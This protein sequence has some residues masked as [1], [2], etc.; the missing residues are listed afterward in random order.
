MR[1][2]RT[3]SID[4]GGTFTDVLSVDESGVIQS[5]KLPTVAPS[6]FASTLNSSLG[7]IS[8]QDELLYST[9]VTLNSLLT[10]T[11]P[12]IG[13]V[14]TAGFR[15]ILETARLP[16]SGDKAS[17]NQLPRRLVSIEWVREIQ[18]RLEATGAVRIGIDRSEIEA[19]AQEYQAADISVVAVSLL[20]SYLD[21]AHEQAVAEVFAE[22]TPGI[23]VVLSST[24]L[25]ELREYERTLT[26]ALNSC[27]IPSLEEHLDSLVPNSNKSTSQIWL[28]QSNGGLSSAESLSHQPLAT[29][30]SGPGAAVVGMHWLGEKSGFE[31]FI[32]LDVGGTSTDVALITNGD[33]ALTTR[34]SVAGFPIKTP[35]LDVFSIGAGGGSI[36]HEGFDRRWH[37]GPE[38]AGARPG[39]ACYGHGGELPTLT[40]AQLVLGRIPDALLGGSV[41]LD[42]TRSWDV[43]EIFG[44]NRGFDVLTTARGILEIASH[45]MC[46]AIRR[47]SVSR[48]CS[49]TDHA[50]LAMGGAGP[51]HAAE[52]ADLLGMTTVIVP[53]QPGLAAAWGLLAA[54]VTRDFVL[55]CGVIDDALD[56]SKIKIG[57]RALRGRAQSWCE[58]EPFMGGDW[59]M[60]AKLDL[61]YVGMTQELT[62][63]CP[64]GSDLK[65]NVASTIDS[66]HDH[67][68]QLS[69]RTWRDREAVEIVNLRLTV[70]GLRRKVDLPRH[71]PNQIKNTPPKTTR[72]VGYLGTKVLQ[73]TPI[74]DRAALD[75]TFQTVGPAII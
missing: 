33:Y 28:M 71:V 75:S 53:P 49:P 17:S 10:G 54:D 19:I 9:T 51:L 43:L 25:P 37:V 14:V 15:D 30:L 63:E 65:K 5:F 72:E 55:P 23:K 8:K 68:E 67:F 56:V 41:P 73:P 52:L 42:R 22:V 74:Y 11:L 16:R 46:G 57:L 40:D 50:L 61:R 58:A 47:V 39:P 66:F 69:G 62:I 2:P 29:A 20:H 1:G 13:L 44:Q 34:G 3:I 59:L 26:T 6:E 36:A 70:R 60:N 31:N 35:M 27:L 18:A 21:P 24:V 64:S 7:Q 48:G 45:N 4:V 12:H 38:S 32:T